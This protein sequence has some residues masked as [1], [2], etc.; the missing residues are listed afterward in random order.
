MDVSGHFLNAALASCQTNWPETK[1]TEQSPR[2]GPN[3]LALQRATALRQACANA[4][5]ATY[6]LAEKDPLALWEALRA[7]LPPVL[8]RGDGN[9]ATDF[10]NQEVATP[11][12]RI[13]LSSLHAEG[14]GHHA[15]RKGAQALFSASEDLKL[16]VSHLVI[17]AT[18]GPLVF[19]SSG[20]GPTPSN[21]TLL[22]RIFS[23]EVV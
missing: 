1:S 23:G 6:S 12:L 20:G 3:P 17:N 11:L 4:G 21:Q 10:G 5:L 13:F 22:P 16:P 8:K 18:R 2:H 7:E 9:V 14:S 15:S 19:S